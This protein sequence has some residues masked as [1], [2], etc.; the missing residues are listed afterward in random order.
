MAE[1]ENPF[2]DPEAQN[3]FH[4]SSVIVKQ[5]LIY[6]C[7]IVICSS[8]QIVLLL[9]ISRSAVNKDVSAHTLVSIENWLA[10]QKM[11]Q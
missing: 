9:L 8:V 11:Q 6:M 2:A 7:L 5:L 1:F 4:V 3:L 10:K